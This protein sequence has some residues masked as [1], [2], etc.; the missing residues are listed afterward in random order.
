MEMTVKTGDCKTTDRYGL[1]LRV[2]D[3]TQANQGYLYGFT[4]DGRYALRKWDGKT[5]TS[6]IAWTS[7][8]AIL[9]GP[10]QTNRLGIMAVG[11]RFIL[12]ANGTLLKEAND[13][14]YTEGGFGVFI[15][16]NQTENFTVT[17]DQIAYWENPS[18]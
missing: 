7:S 14:S 6:L 12:Y 13:S 16:A 11:N 17:I 1:I 15:G 18:P 8:S 9:S 4:C 3:L 2:P 10:N 5:M